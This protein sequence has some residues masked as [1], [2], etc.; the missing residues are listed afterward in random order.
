MSNFEHERERRR[1][2]A[3]QV[4]RNLGF[5][6]ARDESGFFRPMKLPA[7]GIPRRRRKA[8]RVSEDQLSLNFEQ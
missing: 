2:W 3:A 8:R 1:Q 5:G 6:L 4:L 7:P